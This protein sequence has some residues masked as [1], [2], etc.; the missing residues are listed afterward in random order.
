MGVRQIQES[1]FVTGIEGRGRLRTLRTK[2]LTGGS[3]SPGDKRSDFGGPG[4]GPGRIVTEVHRGV[5][6]E[7]LHN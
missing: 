7:H 6:D 5:R 2:S 4:S 1:D 3:R